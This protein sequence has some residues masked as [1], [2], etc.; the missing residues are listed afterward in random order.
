MVILQEFT[1][2]KRKYADIILME[3]LIVTPSMKKDMY[4]IAYLDITKQVKKLAHNAIILVKPAH[5]T[6]CNV[7][8]ALEEIT[9]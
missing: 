5:I 7:T 1:V 2:I 9:D 8:L 3:D 4:A 6:Q